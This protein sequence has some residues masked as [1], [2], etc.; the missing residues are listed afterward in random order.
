MSKSLRSKHHVA[1]VT[2]LAATR[3]EA[4]LT[5]EALARR[6][7][8]HR[9]RI[10]RIESGERR[11]DVPE[12]IAI[13]AGLQMSALTLLARVLSWVDPR[14]LP[15]QGIQ[16]PGGDLALLPNVMP[17]A[18]RPAQWCVRYNVVLPLEVRT[19]GLTVI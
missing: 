15:T 10:A 11:I 9:T 4:G 13:A 8:W 18:L 5:Q 14:S 1:V 16:F 7:G 17:E 6:L 2:V 19:L 12:F 3:R